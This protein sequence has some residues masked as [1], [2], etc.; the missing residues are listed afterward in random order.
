MELFLHPWYMIAGGVLV[1]AP[2]IIHLINR[3]RFKRIRWAAMEFLLKSQKRNRRR[4]IIEQLLLLL[5]RILMVLLVAFLVARFVGGALAASGTGVMHAIVIDDTMSMGDRFA[6]NDGG[7][8]NAL[9]VARDQVADLVKTTALA[10]AAQYVKVMLL[11]EPDKVLLEEQI[12]DRTAA[13]L[14]KALADRKPTA[15]HIPPHVGLQRAQEEIIGSPQ[16]QKIVHFVSDFRETDWSSG[17]NTGELNKTVESLLQNKINLSLIDTAHPFRKDTAGVARHHDNAC[18]LSLKA[19]SRIIP[20]GVDILFEVVVRNNGNQNISPQLVIR[21]DGREE[22]RGSTLLPSVAPG[23]EYT[24][25]F[26]LRFNKKSKAPVEFVH[27]RA[28]IRPGETGLEADHVRDLVL[29]L[30]ERIPVLIV[31]GRGKDEGGKPGGDLFYVEE[32]INATQSYV[33]VPVDLAELETR[34]LETY[35]AVYL[36]NVKTVPEKITE[37]LKAYVEKGGNLAFFLGPE[38]QASHY[39]EVLHTQN[40]G[41]FPVMIELRPTEPLPPEERKRRLQD[42]PGNKILYRDRSHPITREAFVLNESLHLVVVDRFHPLRPRTQWVPDAQKET[43]EILTLPSTRTVES[44]KNQAQDL[45][46]RAVQAVD[47]LAATD[48]KVDPYKSLVRDYQRYVRTALE[49]EFLFEL[50]L[51]L[52]DMLNNPGDKPADPDKPEEAAQPR[53]PGMPA[54]WARPQMKTLAQEINQVRESALFGDPLL[55]ARPYGKGKVV[56]FL[57]SAG[58]QAVTG[59]KDTQWNRLAAGDPGSSSTFMPMMIELQLYLTSQMDTQ[60]RLVSLEEGT[61]NFSFPKDK[62]TENLDVRFIP[63]PDFRQEAGPGQNSEE[64]PLATAKMTEKDDNYVYSFTDTKRPGVY[65]FETTLKN[66]EMG[67]PQKQATLYAFNVNAEAE[68]DLQRASRAQ[69]DDNSTF[70]D[71]YKQASVKFFDKGDS[72]DVFKAKDPDTSESPWLYLL[73]LVV[74]I[75]EQ[76]LAVHLSFHLKGNESASSAPLPRAAAA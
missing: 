8:T 17:P 23:Q 74:L 39:N 69:L 44:F 24:H 15:M 35:A 36:L 73:L 27:V 12:S 68:S 54:L 32:G 48:P 25:K 21:V 29:E 51:V 33:A 30:R 66:P 22:N 28:E 9:D 2:V 50:T 70:R 26:D 11:S 72:F 46:A 42:D 13:N 76:A 60:N 6:K 49:K 37:R 16:G 59:Q 14:D 43:Q 57:S 67:Q 62:V 61:I 45:A 65:V 58:P 64:K 5:L 38:I 20:E 18:I 41:L 40:N 75:C 52:D 63:H 34:P 47:E 4:L 31:D 19:G 56:A 3:M 10:S 1:S 7:T 55:V 71:K 53:R